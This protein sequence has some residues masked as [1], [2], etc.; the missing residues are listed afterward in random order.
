M[1]FLRPWFAL[2]L[3]TFS[4]E[5]A[6]LPG[7]RVETL[8]RAPGFVTSVVSDSQ[9]RIYFTTTDGW[10][11]RVD[12]RVDGAQATP[13]ASL[14]TH[15]GG[16]GG[17]L[18]M[19]L[20][21]DHTAVVH[22]TTWDNGPGDLA[23]VLDDVVSRVDLQS[24]AETVL[25]TF[26]CDIEHRPDGASSEHHGG[27]VTVAPDGSVFV[28][29]GEYGGR[30]IA[31]EPEWNGGKI[32]RIDAAGNATQW[33]LGMR[34][35]YDLA[36]DPSLGRVVV[37]DNGEDG[38]DEINVI[39]QGANCGWPVTYG[40]NPPMAGAAAPVYVFPQTV[41][42]T[43]V[44]RLDGSNPLLRRGYLVGAFV[45]HAIYYFPSIVTAV[46]PPVAVVDEFDEA[47][48]D[49]T[50]AAN[51]DIIFATAGAAGTAIHRLQVPLRGDCNGDGVT[52]SRDVLPLLREINDGSPPRHAMV[53]A[54]GGSYAGSWGC[55]ANADGLIDTTD[56]D[57]L[58]LLLHG[59][60]RAVGPR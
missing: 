20:L 39:E 34:N 40:S 55:D 35:P 52:D 45:R 12:G 36:W 13:I 54:Q 18:G 5:G 9:G 15:A 11:H 22:Y 6:T 60:R 10:I 24:G 31:Q 1:T 42:P 7:F 59:R 41:A 49:V 33:A 53:D 47:V 17:L 23:R 30:Q 25:H 19:A 58:T 44:A 32:W 50:Q 8:V 27:N 29:I 38:G 2:L 37:A 4:A 14:P 28:G 56:L 16:N 43:G 51:G 3:L 26:V 21:D 48:I 57:A 46:A